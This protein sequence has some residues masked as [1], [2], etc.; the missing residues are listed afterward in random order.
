MK[1]E[2]RH[3]AIKQISKKLE[4][5]EELSKHSIPSCGW[6]HSIRTALGMTLQQ[7]ATRLGISSPAVLKLEKN[8]AA[9]V[10]SL[11][12][13]RAAAD[14]LDCQLVYALVPKQPF[15]T[16]IQTRAEALAKKRLEPIF[17]TMALE[18]QSVSFVLKQ[19]HLT[20]EIENIL[21]TLPKELWDEL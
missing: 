9:D 21:E 19:E 11:K 16:L 20:L 5:Y 15:D 18:E 2:V 7:L 13:L 8:E 4:A 1:A 12:T 14:A 3:T 10:I 17:H 6:V